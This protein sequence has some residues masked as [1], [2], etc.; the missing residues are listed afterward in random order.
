MPGSTPSI[1]VWQSIPLTWVGASSEKYTVWHSPI[2]TSSCTWKARIVSS[3]GLN[4]STRSISWLNQRN[5]RPYQ[6]G[7]TSAKIKLNK[8]H[9]F[10]RELKNTLKTSKYHTQNWW[11]KSEATKSN[12]TSRATA[13]ANTTHSAGTKMEKYTA[14]DTSL[15]V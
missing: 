13:M 1:S 14:G 2:T 5:V 6:S 15:S 7:F 8:N 11:T 12:G 10:C 3:A 9:L 4:V